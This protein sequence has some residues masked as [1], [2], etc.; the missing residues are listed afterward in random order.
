MKAKWLCLHG[1]QEKL[2]DSVSDEI[3]DTSI[4]TSI[5]INETV[6]PWEK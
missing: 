6:M 5:L 4:M 2:R 1:E 3:N